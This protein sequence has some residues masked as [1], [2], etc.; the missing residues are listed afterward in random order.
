[1][2]EDAGAEASWAIGA[3][4]ITDA[5]GRVVPITLRY[6]TGFMDSAVRASVKDCVTFFWRF[7]DDPLMGAGG[8]SPELETGLAEMENALISAIPSDGGSMVAVRL[9]NGMVEYALAFFSEAA[10]E[11]FA[12]HFEPPQAFFNKFAAQQF[13]HGH[14][15]WPEYLPNG[16]E[17]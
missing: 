10:H 13:A 6:N 17:A 7:E 3:L 16:F 14:E 1:M 12:E 4:E 5:F 2:S 9:G 11:T 8:P 15:F